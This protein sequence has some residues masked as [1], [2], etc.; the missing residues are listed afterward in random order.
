MGIF[1]GPDLPHKDNICISISPARYDGSS[2]DSWTKSNV[3]ITASNMSNGTSANFP[4]FQSNVDS[5]DGSGTSTLRM[6]S[7]SNKL[8]TGSITVNFWFN[9][10]GASLNV[11]GNNNWRGLLWCNSGTAGYPVTM[12]L[13]QSYVI[14]FSTGHSDGYRRYLDSAFAPVS[15]DSNGWQ[16]ITYTYDKA[17]GIAACYKNG[18]SVRSGA[19]T[20]DGSNGSP[21]AAGTALTYGSYTSAGFGHGGTATSANPGGDGLVPGEWGTTQIWNLALS[22]D[23]VLKVHNNTRKAYGV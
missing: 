13:E 7:G 5:S 18:S 22:S 10:E 3:T 11:G 23:E 2:S 14:N 4:T 9:L 19:M 12:V 6:S 17:S 16:M 15:A 21:T 8:Q 1:R 20:T